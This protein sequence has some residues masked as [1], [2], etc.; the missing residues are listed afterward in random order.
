[1]QNDP[2][3]I[4][5]VMPLGLYTPAINYWPNA[6]GKNPVYLAD[7]TWFAAH[8]GRYWVIRKAAT[9][10][11]PGELESCF[12][13]NGHIVF[14]PQLWVLAT[15]HPR[16]G[17]RVEP[18]W[19]G[20]LPMTCDS[21]GYLTADSDDLIGHY[22]DAMAGTCGIEKA[23]WAAWDAKWTEAKRLHNAA[24]AAVNVSGR[25]N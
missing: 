19:R 20:S 8:A 7:K 21:A 1:M 4:A 22:L 23:E 17:N 9:N 14:P 11:F 5:F 10:E 16:L 12:A 24:Y 25:V 18:V 13:H 6:S 15:H 2:N 3:T